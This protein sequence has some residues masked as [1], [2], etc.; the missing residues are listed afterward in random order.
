MMSSVILIV[1][2]SLSKALVN[3]WSIWFNLL[4]GGCQKKITKHLRVFWK[5]IQK[6]AGFYK[7]IDFHKLQAKDVSFMNSKAIK[8][9]FKP[10][11]ID[12]SLMIHT[13]LIMVHLLVW[14]KHLHLSILKVGLHILFLW[15]HEKTNPFFMNVNCSWTNMFSAI[16]WTYLFWILKHPIL[17][18]WIGCLGIVCVCLD[19]C[20]MVDVDV[21][22]FCVESLFHNRFCV[23]ILLCHMVE[24]VKEDWYIGYL[25]WVAVVGIIAHILTGL[26][27]FEG[28][29]QWAK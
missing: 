13:S 23:W 18:M 6:K 5:Q 12:R 25:I 28:V 29:N 10:L 3:S 7:S 1:L 21:D 22:V 20:C 15:T 17:S 11:N 24:I 14:P 2:Y 19:V 27:A 9:H 4:A 8:N 26:C 16:S